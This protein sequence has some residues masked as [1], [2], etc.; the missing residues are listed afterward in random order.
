MVDFKLGSHLHTVTQGCC[1][2]STV[3]TGWEPW[4]MRRASVPL[5]AP[6]CGAMP[7]AD[8]DLEECLVRAQV[9][10]ET[11]VFEVICSFTTCCMLP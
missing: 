2:P 8:G 3:R 5:P 4:S 10:C 11:V 9:F 1:Q 7:G 6:G